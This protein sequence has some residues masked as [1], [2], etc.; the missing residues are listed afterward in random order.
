M[1]DTTSPRGR[2]SLAQRRDLRLGAV[3]RLEAD[4]RDGSDREIV[5][6]THGTQKMPEEQRVHC[7]Y[8]SATPQQFAKGSSMVFTTMFAE[9]LA[10]SAT[11]V[12]RLFHATTASS[13]TVVYTPFP[14]RC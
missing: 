14:W 11:G 4:L 2:L 3:H 8:V 7:A 6:A 13:I 5:E 12:F 1:S 9:L 10:L